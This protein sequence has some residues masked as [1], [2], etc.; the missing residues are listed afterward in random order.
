MAKLSD[1]NKQLESAV[2]AVAGKKA[3]FEAA[4]VAAAKA[5]TEYHQVVE[6]VRKLHADYQAIMKDILSFGGTV[7]SS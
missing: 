4:K 5:E 3:A 1:I 7:H 6:N 2:D